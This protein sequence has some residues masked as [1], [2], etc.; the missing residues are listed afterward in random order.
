MN[1]VATFIVFLYF[2]IVI[3]F[4]IRKHHLQKAQ[5]Q[6][7]YEVGIYMD[8]ILYSFLKTGKIDSALLEVK[9]SLPDGNMRKAVEKAISHMQMTFDETDVISNSLKIIEAEYCCKRI[10]DIHQ[11][12]IHVEYYGGETE[13]PIHLLL[14]D[15]ER[16]CT[17]IKN[18]MQERKKMFHDIVLSVISSVVICGMVLHLPVMNVDISRNMLIQILTII[19]LVVDDLIIF[20]GQ[21]YLSVDY[22][23][24]DVFDSKIDYAKKMENYRNYNPKREKRFSILLASMAFIMTLLCFLLK[25]QWMTLLGIAL[26][27]ICINQHSIGH[28]LA[29]K[30]LK[31]IIRCAFPNWL[32][33]LVLLLQSENVQVALQKSKAHVPEVLRQELETLIAKLEINPESSEPYH[34]FLQDFQMPEVYATMTMLYSFSVGNSRNTSRQM[35]ELVERNYKMQEAAET[36]RLRDKNSGMYLLFLAPVLTASFKLV[37]DMAVFMLTFLSSSML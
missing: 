14:E 31:K 16:W 19:L 28:Y 2:F 35:S 8:S 27:F 5:E 36:Q 11:F 6:R 20:G 12:M 25:H 7:F 17:R 32:M 34:T 30:N 21:S 1:I 4:H 33:D 15:K 22:L 23:L 18:A 29:G 37:V 10:T 24:L 26:F 9:D 3:H 13:K